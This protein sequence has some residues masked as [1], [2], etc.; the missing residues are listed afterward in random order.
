MSE[1]HPLSFQSLI[2][3]VP[4]FSPSLQFQ[5]NERSLDGTQTALRLPHESQR[6]VGVR[7]M[8]GKQK[9]VRGAR[10][11]RLTQLFT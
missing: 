2:Y 7:F 3:E 1:V 9:K 5:L 4:E 11:R 10:S 8:G 6:K